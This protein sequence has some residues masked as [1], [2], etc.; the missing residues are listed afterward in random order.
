[1]S[2]KCYQVDVQRSHFHTSDDTFYVARVAQWSDYKVQVTSYKQRVVIPTNNPT[3]NVI[4]N[5]ATNFKI[6]VTTQLVNK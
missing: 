5:G 1:M 4:N 3:D 2:Y 6:M